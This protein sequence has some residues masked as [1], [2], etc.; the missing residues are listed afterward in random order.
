MLPAVSPLMTL[1][2][3]EALPERQAKNPWFLVK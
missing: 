2:E 3:F 1:A